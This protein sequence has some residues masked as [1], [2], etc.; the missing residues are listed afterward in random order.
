MVVRL[1]KK[2]L[3]SK[4]DKFKALEVGCGLGAHSIMMA[5]NSMKVEALDVSMASLEILE[6]RSRQK[7]L[8]DLSTV[9]LPIEEYQFVEG[10]F[11]LVLDITCLQHIEKTKLIQILERIKYSIKPSG[12]FY[13]WFVS[14][15]K[16]I[17]DDSFSKSEL[18][19][20]KIQKVFSSGFKLSF[21]EYRYTENNSKDF[22]SFIIASAQREI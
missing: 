15:A 7:D 5:E 18:N 2:L 1:L 19:K 9:C 10:T 13:S 12:W 21:D 6:R 4:K 16:N 3:S 22:I 8:I 20:E 11:D 14:D 17:N